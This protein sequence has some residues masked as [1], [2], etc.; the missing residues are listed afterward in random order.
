MVKETGRG[1]SV[2]IAIDYDGTI[3]EDINLFSQIVSLMKKSGHK[4]II[5]TMRYTH[6]E[7]NTL[8]AI[9]QKN[10]WD[11]PVYY[12]GR[13]AKRDFMFNLGILVDIW[14]DDRPDWILEDSL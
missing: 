5:V 7:D 14:I 13:K 12:T 3:T 2:I 9:L 8:N 6:E 1:G 4:P 11:V 10:S